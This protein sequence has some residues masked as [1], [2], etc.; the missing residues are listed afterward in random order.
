MTAEDALF[1][2]VQRLVA[3]AQPEK[4]ILFGSWA[5]GKNRP[6]SDLDLLVIE[7][8]PFG[9][10][11]SRLEEIGRIERALGRLPYATDILVYSHHEIERW[12][13]SKNH[14]LGRAIREGKVLY[15]RH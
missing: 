9:K 2:I 13:A 6:D 7:S 1:E 8:E 12:K 5:T 14:V 3:T 4:I 15:A 10:G 11:R